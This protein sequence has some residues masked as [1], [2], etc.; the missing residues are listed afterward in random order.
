MRRQ[1]NADII[2]ILSTN[3]RWLF[4]QHP[5]SQRD[6]ALKNNLSEPSVCHWGRTTL[7]D[8]T[9]LQYLADY[10]GVD[11]GWFFTD[12]GFEKFAI[13]TRKA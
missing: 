4:R 9:N 5:G 8:I 6:F 3:I 12:H 7:P 2:R 11:P 13:E 10:F 1:N